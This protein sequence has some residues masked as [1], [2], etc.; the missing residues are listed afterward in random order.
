MCNAV[1]SILLSVQCFHWRGKTCAELGLETLQDSET[2]SMFHSHFVKVE[3]V[4]S[5]GNFAKDIEATGDAIGEVLRDSDN[6]SVNLNL[7]THL[8]H[9]EYATV[10]L[11]IERLCNSENIYE[12]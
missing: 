11:F 12:H 9:L 3:S 2:F 7:L 10:K 4:K 1:V 6:L 8:K 5:L